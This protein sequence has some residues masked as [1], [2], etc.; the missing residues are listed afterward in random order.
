MIT[1][2]RGKSLHKRATQGETLSP[3]EHDFLNK[4]YQQK[5]KEE[6]LQIN[7]LSPNKDAPSDIQEQI[8]LV[9]SQLN[10]TTNRLQEVSS[11][12]EKLRSENELLRKKVADFFDKK[13]A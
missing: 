2:E 11:L 4:W 8:E 12:N 5:D 6:A 3:E 13:R 10:N 1:D 7:S 9:L